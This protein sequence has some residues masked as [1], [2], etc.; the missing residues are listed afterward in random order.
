MEKDTK[1]ALEEF[2]EALRTESNELAEEDL[3]SDLEG[4]FDNM[5][6]PVEVNEA[7]AY[8]NCPNDYSDE[9]ED[10]A[11]QKEK[12]VYGEKLTLGLMLTACA[13]CLGIIGVMIYWLNNFL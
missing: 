5:A 6:E 9:L 13:L 10:F 4:I 12:K 7:Q 3:L 8:S 11:N 1:K 2:E